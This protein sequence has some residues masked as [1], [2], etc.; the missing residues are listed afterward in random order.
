MDDS[1][2]SSKSPDLMSMKRKR[3][4]LLNSVEFRKSFNEGILKPFRLPLNLI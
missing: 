2:E 4:S 1:S 3:S